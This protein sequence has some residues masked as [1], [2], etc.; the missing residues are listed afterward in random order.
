MKDKW[1]GMQIDRNA[2][3]A[4]SDRSGLLLLDKQSPE[5]LAHNTFPTDKSEHAYYNIY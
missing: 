2:Q 5:L 3:H 4:G 1:I